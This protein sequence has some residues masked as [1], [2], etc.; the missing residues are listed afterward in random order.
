PC[1]APPWW[2]RAEPWWPP[3]RWW[4]APRWW[5][6]RRCSRWPPR[7]RRRRRR[8]R[9]RGR[10]RARRRRGGGCASWVLRS[11]RCVEVVDQLGEQLTGAGAEAEEVEVLV[12]E[13]ASPRGG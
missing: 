4:R 9:A 13:H 3:P 1:R 8:R 2:W 11:V 7:S 10:G 5:A 6:A 12:G